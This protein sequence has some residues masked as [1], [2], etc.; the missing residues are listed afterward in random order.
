ME[1]LSVVEIVKE[2]TDKTPGSKAKRPGLEQLMTDVFAQ[3]D[4]LDIQPV[5]LIEYFQEVACSCHRD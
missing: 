3:A 1:A 5:Q 4:E 2:Y